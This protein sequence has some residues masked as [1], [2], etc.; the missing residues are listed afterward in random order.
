M[1][2]L[3]KKFAILLYPRS[4]VI[5]NHSFENAD[6]RRIFADFDCSADVYNSY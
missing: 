1:V 2:R 3:A 6:N 4:E 5:D